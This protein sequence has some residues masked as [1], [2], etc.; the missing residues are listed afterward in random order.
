MIV[1]ERSKAGENF[2]KEK[3]QVDDETKTVSLE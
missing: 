2:K 1:V 3:N